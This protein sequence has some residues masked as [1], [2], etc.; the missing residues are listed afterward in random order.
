MQAD[1]LWHGRK[2]LQMVVEIQ[3][4]RGCSFSPELRP[5]LSFTPQPR[6]GPNANAFSHGTTKRSPG[7]PKAHAFSIG[8]AHPHVVRPGW[9]RVMDSLP[10]SLSRPMPREGLLPACG[11][12]EKSLHDVTGQNVVEVDAV[13]TGNRQEPVSHGVCHIGCRRLAHSRAFNTTGLPTI[14]DSVVRWSRPDCDAIAPSARAPGNGAGNR[15]KG[16]AT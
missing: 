5:W 15:G 6:A 10:R 13:S 3:P 9:R 2:N 8:N 4:P 14:F 12:I 11:A 7:S 1:S 16:A